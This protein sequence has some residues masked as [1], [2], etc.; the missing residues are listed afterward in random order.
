MLIGLGKFM[1]CLIFGNN[2]SMNDKFLKKKKKQ[3]KTKLRDSD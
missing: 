2:E 1:R 3:K